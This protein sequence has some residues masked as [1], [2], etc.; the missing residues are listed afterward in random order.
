[1]VAKHYVLLV[2]TL[3]AKVANPAIYLGSASLW[4]LRVGMAPV[5]PIPEPQ[6]RQLAVH[7]MNV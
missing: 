7:E 6:Y 1:M 2:E 4:S 5:D 3:D